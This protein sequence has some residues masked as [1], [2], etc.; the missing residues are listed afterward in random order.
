MP[1]AAVTRPVVARLPTSHGT[2]DSE[3]GL[4]RGQP[5][6]AACPASPRRRGAHRGTVRLFTGMASLSGRGGMSA[7]G[8]SVGSESESGPGAGSGLR[9]TTGRARPG[10]PAG[11]GAWQFKSNKKL[12]VS[13]Q[14]GF[15]LSLS[16]CGPGAALAAGTARSA[17]ASLRLRL[18]VNQGYGMHPSLS[19]GSAQSDLNRSHSTSMSCL[20]GAS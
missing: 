9:P 10:R 1:L 5:R 15:L 20:S 2:T 8:R 16:R 17:K 4:G 13:W 12:A 3:P 19:P 14:H 7:A 18:I 11:P 6:R